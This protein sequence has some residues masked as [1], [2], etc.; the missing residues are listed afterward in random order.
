MGGDGDEM[1]K[2]ARRLRPTYVMEN[3]VS[4]SRARGGLKR[5]ISLSVGGDVV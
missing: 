5:G 2:M 3:T 4:V 1:R